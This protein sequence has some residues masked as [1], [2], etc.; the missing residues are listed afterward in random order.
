MVALSVF[1]AYENKNGALYQVGMGLV[2]AGAL[3]NLID[4]IALGYVRDFIQFDF[5]RSFPIF[6][7]AD[8]CLCIGVVILLIYYIIRLVKE[9]KNARKDK[10]N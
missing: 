6:N 10:N 7:V 8:I 1:Y 2:F 3:G 4:R 9:R 5:W